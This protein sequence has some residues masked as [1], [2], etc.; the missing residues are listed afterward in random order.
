MSDTATLDGIATPEEARQEN[1]K[2]LSFLMRHMVDFDTKSRLPDSDNIITMA[3]QEMRK[4]GLDYLIIDPYIFV[5]MTEGGS[6]ATETEKVRL[7]LTKLQAWSRAKHV[8][9][10]IVA[11]P[12]IQYKDGHEDF[13]PLDIYAIAG[14][15]QWANLADFL[16][17]VRRVN[18]PQEHKVFT[19]VEMLK[20]RDQELCHPGKVYYT[21]QPCGR[22]DERPD[23]QACI[24]E[25]AAQEVME[26]DDQP[27]IVEP[28][29][30]RKRL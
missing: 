6:R 4:R 13:P 24:R 26:K 19:L 3:E 20:V 15:A 27:W 28:Q 1:Q 14:S 17:T 8:W 22:Y 10:I 30:K 23:E 11:H 2:A 29:T 16:L 25:H 5:D 21:R 12:R 9:T 18:K 7:M